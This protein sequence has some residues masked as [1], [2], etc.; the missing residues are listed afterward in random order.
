MQLQDFLL[1]TNILD[2]H[3]SSVRPSFRI[4][5]ALFALIVDLRRDLDRGSE[6]VF[7]NLVGIFDGILLEPTA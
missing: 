6:L 4:A 7:L 3:Q 2:P 1:D 5:M